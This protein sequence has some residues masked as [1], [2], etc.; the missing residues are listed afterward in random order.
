MFIFTPNTGLALAG[1]IFGSYALRVESY[2]S[3]SLLIILAHFLAAF[4]IQFCLLAA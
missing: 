1:S 4:A 2:S 3:T